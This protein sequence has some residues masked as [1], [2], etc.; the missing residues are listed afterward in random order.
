[1]NVVELQTWWDHC[2]THGEREELMG[3]LGDALNPELA[4]ALW[5]GSRGVHVLEPDEWPTDTDP[6]GWRL[7]ARAADFVSEQRRRTVVRGRRRRRA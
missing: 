3:T 4:L 6:G 1:M 2:L 7:T 5:R